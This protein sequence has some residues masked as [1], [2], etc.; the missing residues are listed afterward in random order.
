[1]FLWFAARMEKWLF[2]GISVLKFKASLFLLFFF[3]FGFV[4]GQPNWKLVADEDG[5]RVFSKSVMDS[6]IKAVHVTCEIKANLAQILALLLD[7]ETA[8]QWICHTKSCSVLKRVSASELYYYTE[9]DLPWPLNNRDFVTHMKIF[10]HPVTKIITIT[11]PAVPGILA[12]KEG[13]VRIDHSVGTWILTPL[14]KERVNIDYTLQVDP[15]G[16][17]PAYIVNAF[18]V[19]APVLSIKKMREILPKYK[20]SGHTLFSISEP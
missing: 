8:E 1:M 13:I 4:S 11:A 2:Q 20:N 3:Q 5:V 10:Q 12:A 14:G 19:K 18:A 9:V 6:R 16:I 15:G 17:I 7:V